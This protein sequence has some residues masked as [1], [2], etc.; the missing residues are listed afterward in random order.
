MAYATL[1]STALGSIPKRSAMAMSLCGLNVPSVSMYMALPSAPP[2][3][4][5]SWHVTAS[6]WHSCVLP[7]L[8]SP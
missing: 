1:S 2:W 5:G 3:S 6:V 7:V 8:N 4:S